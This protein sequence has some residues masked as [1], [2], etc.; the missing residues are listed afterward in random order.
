VLKSGYLP[1]GTWWGI[2]VRVHWTAALMALY[3]TRFRF[4]PAAW[5]AMLLMIIFHELG[6]AF[7][8]RRFHYRVVSIELNMVGGLCHWEGV[9]RRI[10]RA[11]VAWGGVMAQGLLLCA[12]LLVVAIH[13]P[14]RN[15]WASQVVLTWT[16]TN[17][18]MILLNLI[19]IPPLDGASA[20]PFFGLLRSRAK[21]LQ[22]HR[23][24]QRRQHEIETLRTDLLEGRMSPELRAQLDRIKADVRDG[25]PAP[26]EA[27]ETKK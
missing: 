5:L 4:M 11:V 24:Q 22:A 3:F 13:G 21:E 20:W 2:P 14:F 19:P 25:K 6:H 18:W 15:E 12:T 23:E 7:W 17:L 1:L 9:P 26:V 27:P 8:V 16:D 10:E